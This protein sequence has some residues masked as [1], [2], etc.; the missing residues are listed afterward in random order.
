MRQISACFL[1]AAL[2]AAGA[3]GAQQATERFIPIGKSPG[4]SGTGTTIGE[5]RTVE[6][7]RQRVTV[8]GEG[9]SV[10]VTVTDATRIWVDR[11]PSGRANL[12]GSFAD[13]VQGRMA[14]VRPAPEGS[15]ADWI[16]VR[17]E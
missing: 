8:A 7:G 15:G 16:K 14:E 17:R 6:P 9:G 11:S 1:L 2:L 4:L 10:T 5:I 12:A 13:L 3:A